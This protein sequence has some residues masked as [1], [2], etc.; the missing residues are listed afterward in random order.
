MYFDVVVEVVDKPEF[1]ADVK[2]VIECGNCLG[3][4]ISAEGRGEER[5][6]FGPRPKNKN[7]LYTSIHENLLYITKYLISLRYTHT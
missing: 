7:D 6:G 1:V 3:N 4:D 5:I 2:E